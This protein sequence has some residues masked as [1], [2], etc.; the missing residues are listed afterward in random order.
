MR[1]RTSQKEVWKL[2]G[3]ARERSAIKAKPLKQWACGK[4]CEP[5]M[6]KKED[7]LRKGRDN[8]PVKALISR[9]GA[10]E[11]PAMDAVKL[12]EY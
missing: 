5:T 10:F 4:V 2:S 8:D 7:H 9:W 3:A 11:S 6:G 12:A 1:I